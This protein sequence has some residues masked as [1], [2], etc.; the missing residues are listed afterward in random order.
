MVVVGVVVVQS[1]WLP[2][3]I[4]RRATVRMCVCVRAPD[5]LQHANNQTFANPINV[6]ANFYW[7]TSALKK[8][9]CVC[10]LLALSP[11]ALVVVAGVSLSLTQTNPHRH[12]NASS[13][14]K[15]EQRL[16]NL[17]HFKQAAAQMQPV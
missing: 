6:N 10:V 9:V 13:V 11:N 16:F 15:P 5:Y 8:P 3:L 12:H 4:S 14:N 17:P 7:A 1:G 2:E